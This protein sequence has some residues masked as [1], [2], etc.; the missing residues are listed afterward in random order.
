MINFF[1]IAC[2]FRLV[3]QMLWRFIGLDGFADLYAIGISVFEL[4]A[5]TLAVFPPKKRPTAFQQSLLIFFG[6]CA[7]WDL[8]KYV[9]LDPY[10]VYM[11]DY[12]NMFVSLAVTLISN[13]YVFKYL[14]R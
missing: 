9:F 6:L 4:A 3:S 2:L 12:I 11:W 7:A 13:K 10:E 14:N 8:Y 1:I 5:L